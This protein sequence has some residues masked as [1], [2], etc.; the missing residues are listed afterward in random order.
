MKEIKITLD[1]K[2]ITEAIKGIERYKQSLDTK[3]EKL[4]E[5]I[6]ELVKEK[7]QSGFD[8]S[9]VSINKY[10]GDGYASDI[11]VSW[12][13]EDEKSVLV[14]AKGDEV[15]FIEF[16][17]GIHFNGA[18]SPHPDGERLG[19]TIGSYGKG[20]GNRDFWVYYNEEEKKEYTYGTRSTMPLYKALCDAADD[21]EAIAREIFS[22]D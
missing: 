15:A 20:Q 19:L 22:N 7:A 9:V 18:G 6:A 12:Q 21:I 10:T 8:S 16:G 5:R 4:R 14:V 13:D 3:A 17:A 11:E 1:T 2:S